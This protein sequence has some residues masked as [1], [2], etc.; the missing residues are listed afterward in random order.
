MVFSPPS[1]SPPKLPDRGV[2]SMPIQFQGPAT[3][4]I[5]P[6]IRHYQKAAMTIVY[7]YTLVLA[8]LVFFLLFMSR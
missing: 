6:A 8:A 5:G 4:L 2:G 7:S 3:P 1:A